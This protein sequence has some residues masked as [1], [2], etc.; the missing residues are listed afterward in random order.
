MLSHLLLFDVL[1][2]VPIVLELDKNKG[3]SEGGA[4]AWLQ[5]LVRT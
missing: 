4:T 1:L 5:V 2:D 3:I